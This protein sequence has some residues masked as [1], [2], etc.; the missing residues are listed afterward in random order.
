MKMWTRGQAVAG[1]VLGAL[2]GTSAGARAD[3]PT[4]VHANASLDTVLRATSWINGTPTR[5]SLQGQVVLVDV[6]TFDCINCKNITP[7]LRTLSRTKREGLA[8]VGIHS[9]ETPYERDHA[10]VVRH[11]GLL[12]VTWPVAIDN[13]FA[14]WKAYGIEYWP[15]QMIFDRRGKLR[16]VVEGD[17]QDAVVD[18]TINALLRE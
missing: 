3:E 9:P 1:V 4:T 2:A 18:A 17:S 14:L 11:L 16:K 6:F 7:N 12:G 8:I 15:T 10:Q 13:D 5:E